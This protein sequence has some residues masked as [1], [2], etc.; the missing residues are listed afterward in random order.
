MRKVLGI[1]LLL[2]FLGVVF[3]V[4]GFLMSDETDFNLFERP[5][6]TLTELTYEANEVSEFMM[7]FSNRAIEI[8][9]SE[10]DQI[11]IKYY[12]A[13]DHWID[14]TLEDTNLELI[15]RT[16]WYFGISWGIWNA[17]P[18]LKNIWVR[19]MIFISAGLMKLFPTAK[20]SWRLTR[21]FQAI[22][23]QTTGLVRN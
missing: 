3:T 10:S 14:V 18:F 6:Y 16:K 23:A 2:V 19:L 9:P 12:E 1:T 22:A 17:R 5:D 21:R 4:V 13:E 11:V 15:N 8:L 7:L 20:I